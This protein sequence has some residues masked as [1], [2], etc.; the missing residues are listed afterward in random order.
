MFGPEEEDG[1][2]DEDSLVEKATSSLCEG[3]LGPF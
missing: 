2:L 3:V 1:S